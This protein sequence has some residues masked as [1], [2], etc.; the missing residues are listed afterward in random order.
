MDGPS[1]PVRG[2]W[3]WM[4][5]PRQLKVY[6]LE[7]IRLF[8]CWSMAP[9]VVLPT[10]SPPHSNSE[11]R[12]NWPNSAP[13]IQALRPSLRGPTFFMWV[14][15]ECVRLYL[16]S[17]PRIVWLPCP[18]NINALSQS[19]PRSCVVFIDPEKKG[20]TKKKKKLWRN[21][22]AVCFKLTKLK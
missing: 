2:S 9:R 22:F 8:N 11:A 15:G 18:D 12:N 13:G 6:K 1:P 10:S 3:A 14:M 7:L 16:P 21:I 4:T 20:G 19:S 17:I 5:P